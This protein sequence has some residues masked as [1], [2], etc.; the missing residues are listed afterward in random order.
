MVN[1]TGR[2]CKKRAGELL[3]L[4][5]HHLKLILTGHAPARGRLHTAGLCDG[6]P[7]CRFC[8]L[9]NETVQQLACC[10]EVSHT[11]TICATDMLLIFKIQNYF[12]RNNRHV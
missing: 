11:I 8:G 5:R 3:Q 1:F 6:D 10:C 12:L 4:D 7:S 2:P 9:E